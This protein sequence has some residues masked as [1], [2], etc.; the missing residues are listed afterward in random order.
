MPN[1]SGQCV[2]DGHG[3]GATPVVDIQNVNQ[4]RVMRV[5]P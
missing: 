4:Q 2:G 3:P 1:R 5:V